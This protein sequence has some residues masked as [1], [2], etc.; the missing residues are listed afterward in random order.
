MRSRLLGELWHGLLQ[1]LPNAALWQAKVTILHP[2]R[3]PW[4]SWPMMAK[5][6]DVTLNLIRSHGRKGI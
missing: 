5:C 6:L 2:L 4:Q 1:G 3:R